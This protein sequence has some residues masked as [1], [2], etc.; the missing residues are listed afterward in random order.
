VR[1]VEGVPDGFVAIGDL[2]EYVRDD[3][4]WPD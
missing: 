3:W 4:P 1:L 2:E